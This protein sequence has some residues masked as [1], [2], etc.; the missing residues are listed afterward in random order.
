MDVLN[1]IFDIATEEGFLSPLK[2]H[3]ARLRLSLY[4]DDAV[5]FTNPKREDVNCIMQIMEAFGDAMGLRINMQK[6]SVAPIRCD[7]IDLDDVLRDFTGTRVHFLIKYLGLPLTLGRLRMVH[8]KYIQDRAKGKIEGWQGRLVTVA[9][10]RELVRSV[11]TSQPVY[12]MTV[13]KPLKKFIK[14]I[15][16]LRRRFLWAGDG[17]LTCGKCKVAWPTVYLPTKNGGLG[18]KDLDLFSRALRLRWMW[19]AWDTRE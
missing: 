8:L 6:S 2:G 11:I 5:I 17:E 12:L 10:R 15:D 19:Y 7:S 14:E 16:K 1:W 18:I 3:Q 9:G 4:A 13:M